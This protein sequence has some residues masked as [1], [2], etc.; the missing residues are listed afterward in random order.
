MNSGAMTSELLVIVIT[1][2]AILCAGLGGL[3]AWLAFGRKRA[4]HAEVEAAHL[5]EQVAGMKETVGLLQNSLESVRG[6]FGTSLDAVRSTLDS[7]LA[8]AS[9]AASRDRRN[10]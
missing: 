3:V 7:R 10:P 5:R 9:S 2:T 1:G 6:Q 8:Q 4:A